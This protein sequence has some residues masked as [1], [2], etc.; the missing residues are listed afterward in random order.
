V[1]ATLASPSRSSTRR[2]GAFSATC[3][4]TPPAAVTALEDRVLLAAIVWAEGGSA[5]GRAALDR[6]ARLGGDPLTREHI[7]SDLARD[8]RDRKESRAPV[9]QRVGG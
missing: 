6:L 8:G 3:T 5:T 7:A 9:K 4:V 1:Q 2:G